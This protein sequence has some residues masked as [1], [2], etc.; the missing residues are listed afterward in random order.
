M[1]GKLFIFSAPSGSGKTTIVRNLL[2]KKLGL[3]F[4]ISATSR[5]KRKNEIHEKDYYFLSADDIKLK[6][7]ND[8]FLEWEEVYEDRFYGTLRSEV[9]RIWN[10]GKHVIFDVDVVGGLNIKKCYPQKALSI[11]VMPPSVEE[12][13][14]RLRYRSTDS[15]EDIKTRV[16]KASKEL[17]YAREFDL[18]IINDDLEKAILEAE[19]AVRNFISS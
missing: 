1:E 6:I 4:S 8:E 15:E 9:E 7:A 3:E 16:N 14:R 19:N 11:F 13:E 2:E 18:V 17:E 10:E 5:P 12:L